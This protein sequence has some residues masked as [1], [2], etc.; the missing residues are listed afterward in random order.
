MSKRHVVNVVDILFALTSDMM[1]RFPEVTGQL[2]KTSERLA[3]SFVERGESVFYI[4][5]PVLG[6]HLDRCID[7]GVYTKHAILHKPFTASVGKHN[8]LP[9]LWNELWCLIFNSESGEILLDEKGSCNVDAIRLLRQGLYLFKKVEID[10]PD[11]AKRES[12]NGFIETEDALPDLPEVW[13]KCSFTDLDFCNARSFS[14]LRENE[15]RYF[16]HL[17]EDLACMLDAV[18]A[19]LTCVLGSFNPKEHLFKHGPGAI[20]RPSPDGKYAFG[21][22]SDRLDSVFPYSEFGTA[23]YATWADTMSSASSYRDHHEK[24]ISREVCSEEHPSRMVMVRKT[25]KAPRLIACEPVEHQWCQQSCWSYFRTR[26]STTWVGRFVSFGDQTPNQRLAIRGSRDCSL[27]TIDLSE[28]SDRVTPSVVEAVFRCN[29]PLLRALAASRTHSVELPDGRTHKLKKFSTM[30]SACTFPVESLVFLV[31]ALAV[32]LSKRMSPSQVTTNV[33]KELVGRISVFGDDIIV[34]NDNF[35]A[36][37]H[38]LEALCFKVNHGKS[39][40]GKR[41]RESCGTDSVDGQEV[42]PVYWKRVS[43]TTPEEV[44]SMAMTAKHLQ[45]AGHNHL[46]S[47]ARET[48]LGR[49][50]PVPISSDSI[51]IPYQDLMKV[52]TTD[53]GT[54]NALLSSFLYRWNKDLQRVEMRVR[55]LSTRARKC[56]IPW[57]AAL[58]QYFTERPDPFTKWEA[59]RMLRKITTLSWSWVSPYQYLGTELGT[60]AEIIGLSRVRKNQ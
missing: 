27:A 26:S 40:N 50:S 55:V 38:A 9:E 20:S 25:Y 58:L 29:P 35:E 60:V 37:V 42:T 47:L 3:D 28:A 4:D 12:V 17:D 52:P 57:D 7:Q 13:D 24:M 39:F 54:K 59:G 11:E 15:S 53:G 33:I 41:F 34:A 51:G 49:L 45:E 18:A 32:D 10:C 2:R 44:V 5:L 14:W 31:V 21:N 16:G 36:T 8:I 23:N 46:A 6:K 1:S 56:A 48:I 30:G 19:R 43:V 22:W